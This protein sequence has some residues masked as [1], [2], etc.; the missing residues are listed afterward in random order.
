MI[1]FINNY[2]KI[3]SKNNSLIIAKHDN[4]SELVYY[5]KKLADHSDY[6]YFSSGCKDKCFASNCDHT[7][8]RSVIASNG[9]CA[10]NQAL[11]ELLKTVFSQTDLNMFLQI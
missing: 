6:S 1:K 10:Q 4:R 2:L 3:D 5:G 8:I 9:E 7:N 11:S